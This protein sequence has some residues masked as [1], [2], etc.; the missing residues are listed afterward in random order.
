MALTERALKGKSNFP[1]DKPHNDI[2]DGGGLLARFYRTGSISFYYRFRWQ[3]KQAI[4]KLGN[5]PATSLKDAR[6]LHRDAKKLV[7][8]GI[9][10][11]TQNKVTDSNTVEGAVKFWFEKELRVRRK[12]T[13][14]IESAFERHIF[15]KVGNRIFEKV[16]TAEWVAVLSSMTAKTFAVRLLSELKQCARYLMIM[17]MIKSNNLINIDSRFVGTPSKARDRVM[18]MEE[19]RQIYDY[20]HTRDIPP[21]YGAVCI[22]M[23]ITGCRSGEL[24]LAK[25]QHIDLELMRW[26][27]PQENSKTF[28]EIVRPIPEFLREHFE[29][30]IGLNPNT[31]QLIISRFNKVLSVEAFAGRFRRF[32]KHFRKFEKWSPHCFR[33]T[34]STHFGDLGIEPY[35]AEKMLGHEMAGEMKTYN[36]GLY[37]RQQNEA[38]TIW[39]NAIRQVETA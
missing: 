1:E 20:C 24:R 5:Y 28:K 2:A 27:V 31:D 38:M 4:F 22:I 21:E 32:Y 18:S 11:R 9:D 33:H 7:D 26:R 19:L 23:M 13:D 10:P 36:K 29:L 25:K 6:E 8:E 34:I 35:V 15:P 30:L 37:L 14:W 3:G 17:D 39:H 12:R 16:T